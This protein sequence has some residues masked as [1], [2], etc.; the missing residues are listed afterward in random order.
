MSACTALGFD[1]GTRRIGVAVGQTLTGTASPLR[2]LKTRRGTPDWE[3]IKRLVEEWE[4]SAMVVGMPFHMDGSVHERAGETQRFARQLH[5]RYGVPVYTVDERLSTHE[6][7][8]RAPSGEGLDAIAAQ[9]IL[10]SWLAQA[11]DGR[12][13]W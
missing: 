12:A 1:L 11:N 10:E 6:A 13:R 9:L 8:A 4:P 2:I 3:A 5:G 7:R